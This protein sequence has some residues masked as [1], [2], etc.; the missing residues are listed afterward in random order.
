LSLLM[1]VLR[2][3][4]VGAGIIAVDRYLLAMMYEV[5]Q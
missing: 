5:R 4:D 3:G 1:A 2:L